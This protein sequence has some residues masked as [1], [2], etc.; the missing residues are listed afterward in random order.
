MRAYADLVS[1]LPVKISLEYGS[2][3]CLENLS[4]GTCKMRI[5]QAEQ[6]TGEDMKE[7]GI[8]CYLTRVPPLCAQE[9]LL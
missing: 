3:V 7:E 6:S 9:L 1:S 5:L 2:K 4:H 8:A